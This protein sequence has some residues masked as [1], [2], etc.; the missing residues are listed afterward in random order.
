[1]RRD[2]YSRYL[3][4]QLIVNV[5]YGVSIGDWPILYWR[6]QRSTLGRAR[7]GSPLRAICWPVHRGVSS[8]SP[9]PLRWTPGWEMLLW[10]IGLF[11][12]VELHQ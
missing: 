5:T 1:M 6:A 7:N 2:A 11:L 8:P 3:L 12:T 4:M 9:S 10:T